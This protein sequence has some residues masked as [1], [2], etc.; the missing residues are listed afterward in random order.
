MLYGSIKADIDM[1]IDHYIMYGFFIFVGSHI[2][3]P[4][5][6]YLFSKLCNSGPSWY[7]FNSIFIIMNFWP[8]LHTS[9]WEWVHEAFN[10]CQ[11]H[12]LN[13]I[14]HTRTISTQ[15]DVA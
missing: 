2:V 11:S 14:A 6:V 3:L 12:A 8:S 9:S 1:P 10:T 7:V 13:V 15:F 5:F 4:G